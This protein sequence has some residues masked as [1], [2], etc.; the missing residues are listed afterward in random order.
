M[1]NQ[2]TVSEINQTPKSTTLVKKK[3]KWCNAVLTPRQG[4]ITL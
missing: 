2:C 3:K 1:T 4:H